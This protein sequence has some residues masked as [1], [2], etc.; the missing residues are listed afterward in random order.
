MI[1]RPLSGR[2][3]QSGGQKLDGGSC[4]VALRLPS[5][6]GWIRGRVGRPDHRAGIFL[7]KTV[8]GPLR[9]FRGRSSAPE[10]STLARAL[11]LFPA[12]RG[13]KTRRR[14]DRSAEYTRLITTAVEAAANGILITDRQGVVRWVNPAF[15]QITGYTLEEVVGRTPR[16]LKSG[17]QPDSF[18]KHMWDTILAGRVWHGELYNRHKDGHLYIEEQTIAPVSDDRGEIT[19]FIGIK[20]DITRRKDY[21]QTLERR[22]AELVLM[23]TTM[24]KITSSLEVDSVLFSIVNAIGDLLPQA[25]GATLQMEGP[26][27]RLVTRAA[28]SSLS[29]RRAPMEFEAGLGIAGVAHRD[30]AIVNVQDVGEDPRFLKVEPALPYRSLVA[31]PI[32]SGGRVLG[33]LSVESAE[34]AAF[35]KHDENLLAL[36]AGWAGI[37]MRHA[38]EYEGRLQAERELKR[39][40]EQLEMMVEQR[41]AD[42]KAAQGKLLEQQRLEQ[43][44]VLAAQ[45]QASILP[46]ATPD[47]PGYEFAGVAFA[48][49]YVSGDM[50]DWIGTSPEHCDLALADI[51]GKGVPAAMMTST[52]RALLRDSAARKNT[53]GAALTQLN[54]SLY[55][56]LTHAGSFITLVVAH[57]DRRT[58]ALDYASAGHTEVL[59]HRAFAG[60]CERLSATGPP[61]GVLPD[62]PIEERR[63]FLCP[64]DFLVLYSDGVT[65]AEDESG[66][67]FGISRLMDA[68]HRNASLPAAELARSIVDAVDAFSK[69]PRSDDLTIIVVRALPRTVSFRI[70]G[71]LER[72]EEA[73]G[74]LRAMARAYE[75]TFGYELELAASE[76][77]T[78]VLEH[79]CR[80]PGR[81]LRGE[82]RLETDRVE[83]DL[84]DDGL[85]F[86]ISALP[87]QAPGQAIERGYGVHIARQLMDEVTY[88]P[89]TSAGNHWH[90]VKR[91]RPEASGDDR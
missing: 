44:V 6:Y 89:S 75:P 68:V 45:V 34:K 73:M 26:S 77:V 90:L 4:Q 3:A 76:I 72:L 56:D 33:V 58:A 62:Q 60:T 70:P 48:A 23:A 50:Y 85:P 88:T 16:I 37:A 39:Y 30:Q 18:Y 51:A 69:G 38:A 1:P 80:G 12:R 20:Q 65:E 14:P 28:T 22:N 29:A 11:D 24:G 52:A 91:R 36:F 8:P 19:H 35:Q 2:A 57:L 46:R 55:D 61:I 25:R 21:E 79:A 32:R 27:G 43:E 59:W 54:R 63:I 67:L 47:L 71:E 7:R 64:G 84:W 9:R 86:D 17:R 31:V 10:E 81:E 87:P 49:R 15:T 82:V 40:S 83:L 41:T 13:T 5:T 74:L 66:R 42:L 53:P 78:N